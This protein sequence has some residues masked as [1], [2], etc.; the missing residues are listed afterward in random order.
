MMYLKIANHKLEWGRISMFRV[1]FDKI[2]LS[3][4]CDEFEVGICN[5]T[6][7]ERLRQT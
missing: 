7:L 5:E 1:H 6:I 3:N 2:K 4:H